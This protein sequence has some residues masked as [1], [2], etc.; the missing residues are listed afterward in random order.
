MTKLILYSTGCSLCKILA[1]LL[2]RQGMTYETISDVET[3]LALGFQSVPQLSVDGKIL[4]AREA[5]IWA[6]QQNNKEGSV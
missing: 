4:C 3:M 2:D 5:I 1:N 6:N